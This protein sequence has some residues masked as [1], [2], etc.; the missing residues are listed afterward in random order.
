MKEHG[1]D[2]PI[3]V[4]QNPHRIRVMLGGFIIAETTQ[5]L[6]LQEATLPPVQYIP[7]E[8]VRMDLLDPTEHHTHCPFKGDASYFTVNGGGLVR[9]NAAWSYEEPFPLVASIK[10]YLAFYPEKVDAIEEFKE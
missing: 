8:D 4:T 6:T 10:E 7:R 1:P 2:H 3:T 5:A 9:E